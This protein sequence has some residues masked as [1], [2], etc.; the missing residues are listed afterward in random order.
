MLILTAYT[1]L[2]LGVP[3]AVLKCWVS[4]LL[5]AMLVPVSFAVHA[6]GGREWT[7]KDTA[8]GRR[9]VLLDKLLAQAAAAAVI[10]RV[11]TCPFVAWTVPFFACVVAVFLVY[12]VYYP[13]PPRCWVAHHA[14]FHLLVVLGCLFAHK[15]GA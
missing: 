7:V 13:E 9:L 11:A 6:I 15:C 3:A 10:Y 2:M 12:Y 1:S 14:A 8:A 5:F 4:S